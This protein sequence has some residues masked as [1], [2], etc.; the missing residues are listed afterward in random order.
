MPLIAVVGDDD[1]EAN[2]IMKDY[3]KNIIDIQKDSPS[4]TSDFL[5]GLYGDKAEYPDFDFI[6]FA[7]KK[8]LFDY[9][10]ADNYTFAGGNTGIC[11]GF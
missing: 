10:S 1:N 7:S 4:T 6:S 8:D 5:T 11:Y 2:A 9:T 3:L